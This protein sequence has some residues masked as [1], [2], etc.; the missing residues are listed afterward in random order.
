VSPTATPSEIPAPPSASRAAVN[1]SRVA[2]LSQGTS[3]AVDFIS[4]QDGFVAVG[5]ALGQPD[6]QNP[7]GGGSAVWRSKDSERWTPVARQASLLGSVMSD[8][9]EWREGV[10]AVGPSAVFCMHCTENELARQ[11]TSVWSSADGRQWTRVTATGL[12]K[13]LVSGLRQTDAGV[14]AYG[15]AATD[16][17]FP[18]AAIWTSADGASWTETTAPSGE[19]VATMVELGQRQF[20]LTFTQSVGA[21]GA[22][23][24]GVAW[25]PAESGSNDVRGLTASSSESLA[26]GYS[27]ELGHGVFLSTDGE[28]WEAIGGLPIAAAPDYVT[29]IG[30]RYVALAP[31]G[32]DAQRKPK[33]HV[34]LST[35]G[36]TWDDGGAL[37]QSRDL[38]YLTGIVGLPG[39]AMVLGNWGSAAVWSVTPKD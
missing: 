31:I 8:V 16:G 22:S 19:R 28:S 20:A 6:D 11:G 34:W 10:L 1:W 18:R 24:D 35:E 13:A 17:D 27:S 38:A 14:E 3:V 15:A 21:L 5:F 9:V 2:N 25:Q 39:H 23:T 29:W 12:E 37:P 32:W 30:D 7:L 36:R 33:W 4:T 26:V